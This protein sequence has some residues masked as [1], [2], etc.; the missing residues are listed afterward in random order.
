MKKL[1]YTTLVVIGAAAFT[2]CDDYLEPSSPSV[3]DAEFVFS[4]TTTARAALEG[5]YE[6]WR[7]TA[8]SYVFGAGLFYAADVAGSDIERHPE[9]YA[10]QIARHVP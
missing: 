10:N 5:G 1:L 4:N 8:N 2:A 6:A 3:V 9:A 7:S